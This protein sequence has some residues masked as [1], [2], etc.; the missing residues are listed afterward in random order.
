M[1]TIARLIFVLALIAGL[2]YSVAEARAEEDTVVVEV[3]AKVLKVDGNTVVIER[4]PSGE[5]RTATVAAD[6]QFIIDGKTITVEELMEGTVLTAKITTI[7]SED[8]VEV[9][10]GTVIDIF[11]MTV[12]VRMDNGQVRQFTASNDWEFDVDGRKLTVREL[13]AHHK[14]TA[15]AFKADPSTM[16]TDETPITGTTKN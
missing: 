1:R 4:I 5:I 16:I 9:N 11:G 8:T 13:R 12:V 15:V 10:S 2:T 14:L 3:S 7:P 6:R